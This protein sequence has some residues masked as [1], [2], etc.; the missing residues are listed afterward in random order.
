MIALVFALALS[1]VLLSAGE[2]FKDVEYI[3][4]PDGK[5]KPKTVSGRLVIDTSAKNMTFSA[6]KVTMEVTDTAVTSALYERTSKPRYAAG[7]LL[8][9]PLLFTKTKKHYL[10]L[11]YKT[12]A[13]EGKYALFHLDKG[14][15][16]RILAAT[17]AALGKKV[18]RTEER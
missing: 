1:A 10:T 4:T 16:Q 7:L 18:E 12:E 5:E 3:Y 8:A 13:G 14:N 11:Q 9:W 17:E 15:Y 2:T 6:K